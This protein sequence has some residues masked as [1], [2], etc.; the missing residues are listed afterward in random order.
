[1]EQSSRRGQ[2]T[3]NRDGDSSH[4]GAVKSR[5]DTPQHRISYLELGK[6]GRLSNQEPLGDDLLDP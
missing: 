1:M 4:K 6:K 3:E 2:R 5:E